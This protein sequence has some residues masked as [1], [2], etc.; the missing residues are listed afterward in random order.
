MFHV[1]IVAVIPPIV[2]LPI[3]HSEEYLMGKIT[4]LRISDSGSLCVYYGLI[5]TL[6]Q[7]FFVCIHANL[8]CVVKQ[9][10]ANDICITYGKGS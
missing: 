1:N 10:G 9:Y 8:N 3:L 7:M 2:L 5:F 4:F 6:F